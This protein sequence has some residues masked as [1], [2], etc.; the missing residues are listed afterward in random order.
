MNKILPII[1]AVVLSGCATWGGTDYRTPS[2]SWWSK[3][4][5]DS[6]YKKPVKKKINLAIPDE[7]KKEQEANDKLNQLLQNSCRRGCELD[8]FDTFP[9]ASDPDKSGG[10]DVF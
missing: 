7:Y 8:E 2:K 10:G 3:I 1:L 6:G 5:G 4:W 9:E